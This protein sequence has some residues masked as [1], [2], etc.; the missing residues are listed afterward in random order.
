ML[1]VSILL[2]IISLAGC[3]ILKLDL[4]YGLLIGMFAFMIT[5]IRSGFSLKDVLRIMWNGVRESFIVVG[6]LLIIGAMTGIWR[7]SDF[8]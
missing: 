2:L 6:V 5:A 1:V 8:A 3:M 4:V 7:G